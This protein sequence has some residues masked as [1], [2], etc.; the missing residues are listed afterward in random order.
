MY[1]T[2]LLYRTICHQEEEEDNTSPGLEAQVKEATADRN[3]F[4]LFHTPLLLLHIRPCCIS[5]SVITHI[6][7]VGGNA[8][9]ET[10][11]I[12]FSA[13][14]FFFPYFPILS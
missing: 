13:R 2:A 9:L 10:K 1:Y 3:S 14:N 11:I 7:R 4:L 8:E 12:Q 5:H 6:S